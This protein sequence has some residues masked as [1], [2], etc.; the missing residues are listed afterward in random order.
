M[1]LLKKW[2]DAKMKN[3]ENEMPDIT[4]LAINTATNAK[5]NEIENEIPSITILATT[6]APNVKINEVTGEIPYIINLANNTAL[7]A[8]ENK[9][10]SL[11]YLVKKN[12]NWKNVT[13]NN[14][15]KYVTTQ[16]IIKLYQKCLLQ[17]QDKQT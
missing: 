17:H 6:A 15:D 13:D 5:I 1:M 8:I 14:H 9:I 4:K 12:W 2:Y 10:L 3:I 16:E 11:S 7:T